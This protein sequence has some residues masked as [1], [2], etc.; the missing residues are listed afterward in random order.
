MLI[1]SVSFQFYRMIPEGNPRS[2]C[3]IEE[4]GLEST[5]STL[6]F[7]Q[8]KPCNLPTCS[9]PSPIVKDIMLTFIHHP[10][11]CANIFTCFYYRKSKLFLQLHCWDGS[12][13][14]ALAYCLRIV[15]KEDLFTLWPW[16]GVSLW[17]NPVRLQKFPASKQ[18]WHFFFP[19]PGKIWKTCA[20]AFVGAPCWSFRA[21]G[22]LSENLFS[23]VEF[24]A[25]AGS[26]FFN[27]PFPFSGCW[28][29]KA[30]HVAK[31]W[32][33]RQICHIMTQTCTL[34][35]SNLGQCCKKA[36]FAARAQCVPWAK[37]AT[38]PTHCLQKVHSLTSP[39]TC[40]VQA[41][42]AGRVDHIHVTDIQSSSFPNHTINLL[43]PHKK[44]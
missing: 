39:A 28:K 25:W 31:H 37:M 34:L 10:A 32:G 12:S 20:M 16:V 22:F 8:L 14:P 30:F 38:V 33:N 43:S 24:I 17:A 6:Q 23:E 42:S 29:H 44:K 26:I 40:W 7:Y 41:M 1:F 27:C 11:T 9:L 19:S 21:W 15:T 5:W 13:N 4:W 35:E 3:K 2:A 36:C 18:C